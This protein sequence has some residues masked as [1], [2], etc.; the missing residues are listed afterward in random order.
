M[1]LN[2][3]VTTRTTTPTTPIT[4]PPKVPRSIGFPFPTNKRQPL[5]IKKT[6]GKPEVFMAEI[7][8]RGKFVTI[9]KASTAEQALALGKSAARSTLGASVRVKGEK[10]YVQL[11]ANDEFRMGMGKEAGITIVQRA[12]SRIRSIGEIKEIK[13]AR[14]GKMKLW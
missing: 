3:R 10:G 4:P 2:Q 5:S 6:K 11:K 8:R 13:I 9:G 14:R 7:R 1:R 12:P